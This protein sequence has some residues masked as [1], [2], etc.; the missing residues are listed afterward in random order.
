[1]TVRQAVGAGVRAVWARL[2]LAWKTKQVL[3][4]RLFAGLPWVFRHT[5]AYRVWAGAA[6]TG[7]RPPPQA[8]PDAGPALVDEPAPVHVPLLHAPPLQ[9]APVRVIGFYLPQFHAIPE[10]D[11]WWGPGF[12]EWTNVRPAQPQFAGHYQ[13]HVPGELGYYDLLDPAVQRRQVELARLYGVGGFCFY[14]YWFGGKRLLEA[15][16]RQYLE[17]DSLDLPFCLCWANENWTRRWD[18]L[19]SEVLIAQQHSPADDLAFIEYVAPYLRDRRYIRIDGRPLLLVYR[20]GLL[21]SARETASRWRQWCRDNGVGELYLACTQSFELTDP[22]DY[23]FDAAVEFPP[24][25]FG[26]PSV[27]D[28]IESLPRDFGGQVYDWRHLPAR[29]AHHQDPGYRVFRGVNPAWDNTARRGRRAT[30][31]VNS[32]AVGYQQWLLQVVQETM[33]RTDRPDERLVFVNAWNE[34]AEGAHL[35]PDARYGYAFLEATRMALARAAIMAGPR[36]A[37][38]D[39]RVAVVV[40]AFYLD[41]FEEVLANV[42]HT[43]TTRAKWFVTTPHDQ[44]EAVTAIARRFGVPFEVVGRPN[45]GRD[46][47]PFLRVL[48]QVVAEGFPWV[49]KLHTKKS[50]HRS[51]GDRW[52][53]DLYSKLLD[54][55]ERTLAYLRDHPDVGLVG[56]QGY[57]VPMT[58]YWGA[59]RDRV[60]ALGRRL[61]IA[62]LDPQTTS[63][64]AGTM[65]YAR[66]EALQPLLHLALDDEHFEP[67]AGQVDGTLAH[68]IER[69]V[70]LSAMAVGLRIASTDEVAGGGAGAPQGLS[71]QAFYRPAPQGAAN[72]VG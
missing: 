33:Q 65:F 31:F 57:V 15:P 24:N 34:W 44:V 35:E 38:D 36:P 52:R 32:S 61:G 16:V 1:M 23:G 7:G 67:E 27:K 2:P 4:H 58:C 68:A 62:A 12:T 53:D 47:L 55:P 13:P 49:L 25:N 54:R 41:V 14:F 8:V 71:L 11:A 63:F 72:G 60:L 10:N 26:P 30:I 64:I 17:D 56:P 20:P 42:P 50:L 59:N 69:V 29:S 43:L 37:R 51:D 70:A 46:V 28:R 48:P 9:N 40:H 6:G 18:G 5:Q 3:K 66:L 39:G 45:R 19:D 21:P 22:A